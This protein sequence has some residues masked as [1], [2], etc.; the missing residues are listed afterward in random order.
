MD[1][2]RDP[3]RTERIDW[4]GASLAVA[5]LGGM[6]FG[7]LEWPPL[8]A[9]HPLVLAALAIGTL[10][11]VRFVFVERRTSNP[12]LPLDLFRSRT[13][14][15]ANLL[16]FLLY[17]ALAVVF[18]LVPMNLIQV[19]R[20]SATQ[21]GAAL[22]PLPL[23]V[24]ALSRWSGGLVASTGSRVPL[25]I[26]PAIAAV[27]IALYAR[28]GIGGSYWATFFP[29]IVVLGLGMAI[30]VAPLTTTV[31]GAVESQHAGTASGIN[32][33]VSRV[34]GLLAVAIFGVVLL[35]AFDA[36]A[37]ASLNHLQLPAAA[38]SAVEQELPKMA[39]AGVDAIPAL[40]SPQRAAVHDAIS[41]AFVF[42]FR[43][44]F[45]G[46]ALL[47]LVAAVFGGLVR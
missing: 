17:A 6:V 41:G 13:F 8:G 4:H 43:L 27:G 2:S 21:A 9:G 28:P 16:T 24:F 18:F 45:C 7:L 14:T 29:A 3:S 22:L 26:G 42:A 39:G 1:E 20:Y 36:R 10:S 19:Q 46:T 32:N 37:R 23:I 33:A 47:A 15:L 5:G 34:A 35:R 30:T 12:M 44:V 25:T 31:M 11:L 38:R 40:D